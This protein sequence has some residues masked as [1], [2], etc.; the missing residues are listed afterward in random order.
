MVFDLFGK[1]DSF[2]FPQLKSPLSKYLHSKINAHNVCSFLVAARAN[3]QNDLAD[4][5][6][7]FIDDHALDVLQSEGFQK[8]P[9][10]RII[11]KSIFAVCDLRNSF[12]FLGSA[13]RNSHSRLVRR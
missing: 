13:T 11:R 5:S 10:V 3:E 6:L 2:R 8:L 1:L 9:A 7:I 12:N 4:E